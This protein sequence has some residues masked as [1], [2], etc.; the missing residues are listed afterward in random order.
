MLATLSVA[1]LKSLRP[2]QW[3]KNALV[4]LPFMFAIRQAWSW[5]TWIRYLD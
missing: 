1:V 5:T 2:Q 4:F 3:I